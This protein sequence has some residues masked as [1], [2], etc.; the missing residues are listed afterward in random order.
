MG[1][2]SSSKGTK[3]VLRKNDERARYELF[4]SPHDGS[5]RVVSCCAQIKR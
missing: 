5:R 2:P 4:L 3:G 1:Q